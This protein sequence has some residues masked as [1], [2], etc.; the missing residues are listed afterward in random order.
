MKASVFLNQKQ[1]SPLN[2]LLF[3]YI[4]A[5]IAIGVLTTGDSMANN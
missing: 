5:V 2:C 3:I 1:L 4:H